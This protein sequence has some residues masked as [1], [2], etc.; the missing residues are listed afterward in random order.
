MKLTTRATGT[1]FSRIVVGKVYEH[2]IGKA[3]A[4]LKVAT[5]S[6]KVIL[7]M[8]VS[9]SLVKYG[10]SREVGLQQILAGNFINHY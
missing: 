9:K 2:H 10:S 4:T 7:S 6:Y 5:H 3:L 8:L 1:V